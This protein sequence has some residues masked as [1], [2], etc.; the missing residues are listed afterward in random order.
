MKESWLI[1][2]DKNLVFGWPPSCKLHGAMNQIAKERIG[3][4]GVWRCISNVDKHGTSMCRAGIVFEPECSNGPTGNHCWLGEL[5]IHC[6][7][8]NEWFGCM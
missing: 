2:A 5:I 4:G 6:I 1:G 7:W 3:G 8:C